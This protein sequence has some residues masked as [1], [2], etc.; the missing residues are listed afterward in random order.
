MNILYAELA[1]ILELLRIIPPTQY[2]KLKFYTDNIEVAKLSCYT[3]FNNKEYTSNY[4]YIK[5]EILK[6]AKT[7]P[8]INH[9][10][11]DI[12]T[13]S[14]Q[15]LSFLIK[16]IQKEHKIVDRNY[17]VKNNQESKIFRHPAT[18]VFIEDENIVGYIRSSIR[19]SISRNMLKDYLHRKNFQVSKRMIDIRS[20]AIKSVSNTMKSSAVKFFNGQTDEN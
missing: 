19:Y 4:S 18:T 13:S 10:K 16:S 17:K 7:F 1:P 20:D 14:L 12:D 9:I 2:Q 11:K 15:K 5:Y 3:E 6:I 8:N